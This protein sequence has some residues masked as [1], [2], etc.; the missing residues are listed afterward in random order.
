MNPW[1]L[2][3]IFICPLATVWHCHCEVNTIT[4]MFPN[5]L[6]SSSLC[7]QQLQKRPVKDKF[8]IFYDT[9]TAGK[10]NIWSKYWIPNPLVSMYILFCCWWCT[11]FLD[12]CLE[13]VFVHDTWFLN[14]SCMSLFKL[15]SK[16]MCFGLLVYT[17]PLL[18]LYRGKIQCLNMPSFIMTCMHSF[19]VM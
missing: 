3:T 9:P 1:C 2:K 12:Y 18:I 8:K 10:A 19:H 11:D 15:L 6:H 17:V 7:I 16:G 5:S 4:T 13:F 14:A